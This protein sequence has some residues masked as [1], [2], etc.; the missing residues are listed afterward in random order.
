MNYRSLKTYM[1]ETNG[2]NFFY[3]QFYYRNT[4]HLSQNF[5]ELNRSTYYSN[6]IIPN[7]AVFGPTK[8]I[9][10]ATASTAQHYGTDDSLWIS[11]FRFLNLDF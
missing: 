10:T 4:K 3:F 11:K 2:S 7:T 9:E 1:E 8:L 6:K 5:T